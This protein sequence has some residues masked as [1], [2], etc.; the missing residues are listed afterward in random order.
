MHLK[1]DC[2][3]TNNHTKQRIILLLTLIF[4]IVVFKPNTILGGDHYIRPIY[5]FKHLKSDTIPVKI[6]NLSKKIFPNVFP[7]PF[8]NAIG[9]SNYK[10]TIL[11]IKFKNN[12]IKYKNITRNFKEYNG[13]SSK[14]LPV[15][16]DNTIGWGETR[17][18]LLYN[19]DNNSHKYYPIKAISG[20]WEYIE[21]VRVIDGKKR[22]F[23]FIIESDRDGSFDADDYLKIIDFSSEE[24]KESKL[25]DI[26]KNGIQLKRLLTSHDDTIFMNDAKTKMLEVIDTKF[27][28]VQHPL[29]AL[30]NSNQD[31]LLGRR[32]LTIHPSLPFA[33]IHGETKLWVAKWNNKKSE[34]IPIIYL[35]KFGAN[36]EFSPDGK[37][38]L[39]EYK[40]KQPLPG[41]KEKYELFLM[42]INENLPYY[43]GDPLVLG[44]HPERTKVKV[45]STNP[46]ALNIVAF[47]KLYRWVIEKPDK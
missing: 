44:H 39:I 5:S 19:L 18:F 9:S 40:E 30:Y 24:P 13:D 25:L 8:D 34:M 20:R 27:D 33:V 23:L 16:S 36:F 32:V 22:Q 26:R 35:T 28:S 46:L 10:N 12:T 47:D 29:T 41:E 31:T 14:F 15:F 7:V 43:L 3:F 1:H 2:C 37:W 17:R 6:F 42:P 11:L 38:L 21:R 45:W 4:V